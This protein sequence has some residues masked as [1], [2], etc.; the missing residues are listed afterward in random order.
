M[1]SDGCR[2]NASES[3]KFCDVHGVEIDAAG[4]APTVARMQL[5]SLRT[6]MLPVSKP[7]GDTN[8]W[9]NAPTAASGFPA[10]AKAPPW[11]GVLTPPPGGVPQAQVLL[12]LPPPPHMLP[13]TTPVPPLQPPA[14]TLDRVPTDCCRRSGIT[15]RSETAA[16]V[17]AIATLRWE[18]NEDVTRWPCRLPRHEEGAVGVLQPL[19]EAASND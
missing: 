8:P 1:R 3:G 11:P 18:G 7:T 12:V 14:P 15:A 2:F 16:A 19:A 17:A 13:H 5:G 10:P 4:T 6:Q 9:E